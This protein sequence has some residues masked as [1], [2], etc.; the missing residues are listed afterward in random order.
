MIIDEHFIGDKSSTRNAVA[1]DGGQ[2]E[3]PA[4]ILRLSNAIDWLETAAVSLTER[5]GPVLNQQEPNSVTSDK[6]GYKTD[7]GCAIAEKADK[8]EG[9]ASHLDSLLRRLEL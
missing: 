9:I 1:S 4:Q 2:P 7:I 5:L 6:E 3:I 8:I